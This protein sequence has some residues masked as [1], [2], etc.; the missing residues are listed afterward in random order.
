MCHIAI[1]NHFSSQE[2]DISA[3]LEHLRDQKLGMVPTK[4][5]TFEQA[6]QWFTQAI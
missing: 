5:T 1:V 2:F 4:V 3:T 6:V